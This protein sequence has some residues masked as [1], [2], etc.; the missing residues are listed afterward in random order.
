MTVSVCLTIFFIALTIPN[1]IVPTLIGTGWEGAIGHGL[2]W[3]SRKATS[4]LSATPIQQNPWA[5]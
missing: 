1:W 2:G 4:W 3:L 5:A